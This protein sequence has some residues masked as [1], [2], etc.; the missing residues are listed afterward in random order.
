MRI[1]SN[2]VTD[3]IRFFRSELRNRYEAAEIDHFVWMLLEEFAGL[4]RQDLVMEPD[5]TVSESVLLELFMALKALRRYQPIQ[6]IIGKALFYDLELK[7]NADTL[8]PRPETEELVHWVLS[9]FA[10]PERSMQVLDMG[11]GSGC[12]ALALKH[13]RPGWKVEAWDISEGALDVARFNARHLG[14]DVRFYQQDMLAT[15]LPDGVYDL[16][17]SNPPYVMNQEKEKM[18]PNVLDYEPHS[19]LFVSD[20][21][22]LV[23]YHAIVNYAAVHLKQGGRLYLEINEALGEASRQLVETALGEARLK[24]DLQQRDR[25]VCGIKS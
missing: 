9:D 23:Y 15:T 12:I 8:I 1:P 5:R 2:K 7:V 17:V 6:Q 14:I 19:A 25:M 18:Q 13:N 10:P 21:N 16:I 4:S 22:P 24:K 3:I 20:Q 11:S